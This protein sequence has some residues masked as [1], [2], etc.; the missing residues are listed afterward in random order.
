MYLLP[1]NAWTYELTGPCST[2]GTVA[3][4]AVVIPDAAP[5]GEQFTPVDATHAHVTAAEGP[6]PW[7]VLLRFVRFV[8]TS[9]DIVTGAPTATVTGDL[10][11][12][13]NSWNLASRAFEVTSYHDG[14]HDGWCYELYEVDPTNASN[15][16]I[17]VHIPDLHPAGGS[18]VPVPA[19]HVAVAGHGS[20]YLPWPIFRHFLDA[21]SASGNIV[22]DQE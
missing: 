3:M 13:L 19:R 15:D 5:D 18:F 1:E 11:L 6:L 20:P 14:E 12:S 7:P 17:D 22:E 2:F 8:E 10:A 9:G 16:Y 21:I 4:L